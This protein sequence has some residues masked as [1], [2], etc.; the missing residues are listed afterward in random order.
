[1]TRVAI[2]FGIGVGIGLLALAG[3]GAWFGYTEGLPNQM[4]PG[5]NA[6]LLEAVLFVVFGWWTA[7]VPGIIGAIAGFGSWLVRPAKSNRFWL[8]SAL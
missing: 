4:P 2:G 5:V 1:M 7:L 6:A 8:T 3:L